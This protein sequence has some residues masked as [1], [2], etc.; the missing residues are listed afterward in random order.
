MI[1]P[2]TS[3]HLVLHASFPSFAAVVPA[4]PPPQCTPALARGS[5]SSS[6]GP[7]AAASVAGAVARVEQIERQRRADQAARDEADF[8]LVP[9][10][11]LPR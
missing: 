8:G 7:S 1:L 4:P 2:L 10:V 11:R 9:L 6:A 3:L 5:A